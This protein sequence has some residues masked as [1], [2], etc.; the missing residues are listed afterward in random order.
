MPAAVIGSPAAAVELADGSIAPEVDTAREPRTDGGMPESRSRVQVQPWIPLVGVAALAV[1][2]ATAIVLLPTAGA[3]PGRATTPPLAGVPPASTDDPASEPPTSLL[4]LTTPRTLPASG[5]T[6][7]GRLEVMQERLRSWRDSVGAVRA[8]VIV[9]AAN[10][11]GSPV[12]ISASGTTWTISDDAG[13]VVSQGRFAHAFPPVVLPGGVVYLIDGVSAT[14]AE[15]DELAELDVEIGVVQADSV[16]PVVPLQIANLSLSGTPDGGVNVSG[17]VTN[18]SDTPVSEA[19]LGV[20]LKDAAG[21][22]VGGAYD[23]AVG[24]LAPG[25]TRSFETAYPGTPPIDAADVATVEGAASGT[26]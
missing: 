9:T 25:A 4:Q 7:P 22:I 12:E 16:D 10:V 5:G 18:S 2:L 3:P 21:D 20:V 17:V 24:G 26:P 1:G 23:V 15:P 8:Q 6:G 14:F 13:R 19:T 11:G